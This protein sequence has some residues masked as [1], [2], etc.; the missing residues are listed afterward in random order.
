MQKIRD[1]LNSTLDSPSLQASSSR[2]PPSGRRTTTHVGLPESA[3]ERR[4]GPFCFS[5]D[6]AP[7]PTARLGATL[8]Q[9]RRME[10]PLRDYRASSRRG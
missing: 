2:A 6:T 8:A 1:K 3:S 9:G 4:P 5:C 7:I 10:P